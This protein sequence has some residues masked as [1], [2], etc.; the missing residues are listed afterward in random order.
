MAEALVAGHLQRLPG[1][2]PSPCHVRYG[3]QNTLEQVF[4]RVPSFPP[5]IIIPP[6]FHTR[7][8]LHAASSRTNELIMGNP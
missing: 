3:A 5:V 4:L 1:F 6:T 2:D 7:L 8:Y